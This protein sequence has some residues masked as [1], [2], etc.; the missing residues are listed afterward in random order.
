MFVHALGLVNGEDG[1]PDW[2]LE[3]ASKERC[4]YQMALYA[5]HL[6]TGSTLQ[7]KS[8]KADSIL[9]YL[10]HVATFLRPH[11][12]HGDPRYWNSTDKEIAREI[13]S[14]TD[15]VRRW[16][17]Q[18]DRRE[19]FTVAMW[20][21]I[22]KLARDVNDD[23]ILPSLRDWTALGL[24]VG[25]R[26]GEWAQDSPLGDISTEP[27]KNFRGE[28]YAFCLDDFECFD[29]T[30]RKLSWT[31]VRD[32]P[33]DDITDA[34]TRFRVQKNGD[35]FRVTK[36]RDRNRGPHDI[37]AVRAIVRIIRRFLRLCGERTDIPIA[38]Y[39]DTSGTVRRITSR[40]IEST[41]RATA[42]VV[43]NLDPVK[44]KEKLRKWSAHSLRVGAAVILY[45]A[46]FT[47]TQIQHLLRWRSLAF[48]EYLRNLG[49]MADRQSTA[50][51]ALGDVIDFL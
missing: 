4:I 50:I 1:E 19:P 42:A 29:K 21:H 35:N 12:Q 32:M 39:R 49:I 20:Q 38:V 6:A 8:I 45:A 7:C 27:K 44:D 13:K 28:P 46:G 5:V 11:T 36:Q 9:R 51:A 14:I 10:S 18:K 24:H 37:A 17:K 15:E 23:E 48:M 43:Y 16:E 30:N 22:E 41:F 33:I 31:E 34:T 47:D 26:L 2:L 3:R 25:L 40:E